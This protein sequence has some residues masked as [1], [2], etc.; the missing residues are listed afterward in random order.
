MKIHSHAAPEPLLDLCYL[1]LV[2]CSTSLLVLLAHCIITNTLTLQTQHWG[3]AA[4]VPFYPIPRRANHRTGLNQCR[5]GCRHPRTLLCLGS[6]RHPIYPP[7][8]S[9]HP[10]PHQPPLSP[11]RLRNPP[12]QRPYY[13]DC[14]P[15]AV[16]G[17]PPAPSHSKRRW[18]SPWRH[19]RRVPWR[20]WPY[21][22]TVRGL[23][24]ESTWAGASTRASRISTTVAAAK[25][26]RDV[27]SAVRC[28]FKA[29]APQHVPSPV[30]HH[31]ELPRD[32]RNG[33][34]A[35]CRVL[36]QRHRHSRDSEP[37]RCIVLHS[38]VPLTHV[39]LLA[40]DVEGGNVVVLPRAW[41]WGVQ[42][43]CLLCIV[44]CVWCHP[45]ACHPSSLLRCAD[46]LDDWTARWL[47]TLPSLVCC[48]PYRW[49]R[50]SNFAV[51]APWGCNA[52]TIHGQYGASPQQVLTVLLEV[53]TYE[54]VLLRSYLFFR[55]FFASLLYSLLS[56]HVSCL[57]R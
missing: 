1:F 9:R 4:D 2:I 46:V 56:S 34:R 53:R 52:V 20:C 8:P 3:W 31:F 6:Q 29:A 44:C 11:L 49:K 16:M 7:A 17:N 55:C 48:G 35:R 39:A 38:A 27:W 51:H 5:R 21:G 15:P 41:R 14:R 36:G 33:R 57:G 23:R 32:P 18:L 12:L 22:A 42:H 43:H 45:P 26:P 13:R 54:C 50:S 30:P 10:A 25:A 37:V 24:N 40:A 19:H 47:C 28:T